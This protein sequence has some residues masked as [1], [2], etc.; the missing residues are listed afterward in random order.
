MAGAAS[1][2]QGPGAEVAVTGIGLLTPAGRG[3]EAT[4]EG[5]C[6]G[7]SL[8]RRDELL[9]GLPVDIS[10]Q[11]PDFDPVA[12]HGRRLARRLDRC[13]HLTLAAALD[14]PIQLQVAARAG[15]TTWSLKAQQRRL[16]HPPGTA[17]IMIGANDAVLPLS[18]PSSAR[19]LGRH[20]ADLHA[21]GWSVLVGTCPD[22]RAATGLRPWIHPTA[23][24]RSQRL[25]QLQNT[26]VQKAGGQTVQLPLD[27]LL[28]RPAELLSDDGCHPS[29]QGY[30]LQ[31]SQA[32]PAIISTSARNASAR[33]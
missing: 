10:C 17:L 20:V 6:R 29:A 12:V 14:Q 28:A 25:A 33:R 13:A 5:V 32:L 30:A 31:V 16:P 24:R 18:L 26:A 3:E 27:D 22:Y 11:V 8:A 9:A 4:W 2:P 1:A 23:I 7:R 19:R 15:A 21:A